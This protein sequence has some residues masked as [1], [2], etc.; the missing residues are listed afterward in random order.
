MQG[1]PRSQRSIRELRLA[2]QATQGPLPTGP[3]HMTNSTRALDKQVSGMGGG[4]GLRKQPHQ[5][6]DWEAM[7]EAQKRVARVIRETNE[8]SGAQLGHQH[9]AYRQ[10]TEAGGTGAHAEARNNAPDALRRHA[11]EMRRLVRDLGPEARA[12]VANAGV[13]RALRGYAGG[14]PQHF[15]YG[16][17]DSARTTTSHAG[18]RSEP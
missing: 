14:G 12:T 17:E 16:S 13:A 9:Q 10:L 4:V 15:F 2:E 7:S 8:R 11:D 6:V 1:P 18:F 3:E 5:A